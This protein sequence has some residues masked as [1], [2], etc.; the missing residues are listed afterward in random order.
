M[1]R[2]P[3]YLNGSNGSGIVAYCE[4][5]RASNLQRPGDDPG[6]L[7][8][9]ADR[10]QTS[11]RS[12]RRQR[13]PEIHR[14]HLI[15]PPGQPYSAPV[16]PLKA[17]HALSRPRR[18]SPGR[19]ILPPTDGHNSPRKAAT[20]AL[21]LRSLYSSIPLEDAMERELTPVE[22]RGGVISGRVITVLAISFVGVVM[23]LAGVWTIIGMPN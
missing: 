11:D 16:A 19:A 7:P 17:M 22:A 6:L 23:A 4:R 8:G 15:S 3:R 13:M 10:R 21:S 9:C 20:A 1:E 2:R 5:R 14:A 12:R 18:P